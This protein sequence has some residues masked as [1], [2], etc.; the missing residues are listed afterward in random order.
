M[1]RSGECRGNSMME[2]VR[3]RGECCEGGD[4]GVR[5]RGGCCR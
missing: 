1:L 5:V 3:V 4:E 2:G